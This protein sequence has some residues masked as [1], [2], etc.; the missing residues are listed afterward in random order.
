MIQ[1]YML[2]FLLFISLP[3]DLFLDYQPTQALIE[4]IWK[5]N[6]GIFISKNLA[7]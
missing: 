1:L 2:L 4:C 7:Q 3:E 6:P 5:K